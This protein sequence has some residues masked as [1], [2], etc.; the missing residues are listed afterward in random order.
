MV[1]QFLFDRGS[2]P[3]RHFAGTSAGIMALAGTFLPAGVE[4][5]LAG[6]D[7]VLF[8]LGLILLGGSWRRLALI[9]PEWTLK[10]LALAVLSVRLRLAIGL[11]ATGVVPALVTLWLTVSM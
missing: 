9:G 11:T 3:Q 2:A 4:H 6:A 10:V 1:Q 7:H 5:V 8:V